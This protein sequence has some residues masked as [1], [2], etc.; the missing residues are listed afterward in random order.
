MIVFMDTSAVVKRYVAEAGS[1][2]IAALTSDISNRIF[3][4]SITEVEVTSA[5]QRRTLSGS[6][7]RD[8]ASAALAHFDADMAGGYS[9]IMLNPAV[10]QRAKSL[11]RTHGLRGYDAVQLATA[12]QV[13]A[14]SGKQ[15]VT[16]IAADNA[17]NVIAQA[18]GLSIENPNEYA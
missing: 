7:T 13:A 15:T 8:A 3:I 1:K 16:F 5:V 11:A 17:L 2:W 6:L 18:E 9:R 10:I 14:R 12:L 4:A